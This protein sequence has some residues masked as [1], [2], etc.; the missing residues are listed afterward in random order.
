MHGLNSQVPAKLTPLVSSPPP[1]QAR[2][3][4][5][6]SGGIITRKSTVQQSTITVISHVNQ[7]TG[8]CGLSEELVFLWVT[9]STA[10]DRFYTTRVAHQ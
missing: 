10:V 3:S 8:D 1:A 4:V 2:V 7:S 5:P 9:T 6:P